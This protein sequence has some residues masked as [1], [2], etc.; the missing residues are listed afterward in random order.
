MVT[1]G[2]RVGTPALATRGL[3]VED[4]H[5]VGRLIARTL[6]PGFDD[7]KSELAERVS[8]IADRFPL[9]AHLGT[10]ATV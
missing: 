8:Q 3:Q 5:E 9:Y 1:S 7:V 10:P 4:F 6:Q 2:L